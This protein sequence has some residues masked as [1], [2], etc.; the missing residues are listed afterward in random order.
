ME[1]VCNRNVI[2]YIFF[3]FLEFLILGKVLIFEMW[4]YFFDSKFKI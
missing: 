3:F 1:Y 2:V 4:I